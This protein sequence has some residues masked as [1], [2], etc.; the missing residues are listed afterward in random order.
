MLFSPCQDDPSDLASGFELQFPVKGEVQRIPSHCCHRPPTRQQHR[1]DHH[2]CFL[3]PGPLLASPS[4]LLFLT[5]TSCLQHVNLHLTDEKT[6]AQRRSFPDSLRY[7]MREPG[8]KL[9]SFGL[10]SSA[11][12]T[13]FFPQ[14]KTRAIAI[15]S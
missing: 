10:Q 8:L 11:T 12:K 15:N 1:N 13:Y 4:D 9:S 5:I 14:D 2:A 6:R 7:S 3:V